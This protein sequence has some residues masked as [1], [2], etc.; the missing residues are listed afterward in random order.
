MTTPR[1]AWTIRLTY[2]AEHD[3]V[4]AAFVN[5]VLHDEDDVERWRHDISARLATFGRQVD[6]IIDLTGLVV[7]PRAA[8]LFGRLRGGVL[9]QYALHSFRYGGDGDTRTSIFTSSVLHKADAN[10]HPT[11]EKAVAAL[12]AQRAAER[13][14]AERPGSGSHAIERP[15][16]GNHAA[17]R[18]GSGSYPVDRS[19][20]GRIVERPSVAMPVV[21]V[22][23]T[24]KP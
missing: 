2:E 24:R 21:A 20:H 8:S 23:G 17:E 5:V 15:G 6:L 1:P 4:H 3:Y 11:R 10:V 12:L 18:P 9:K 7:R 22:P 19:S 14:P 16:S 13:P